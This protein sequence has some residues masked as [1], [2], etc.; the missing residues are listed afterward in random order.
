M[1]LRNS[2]SM[3]WTSFT[4]IP[5]TSAQVLF[6]YVLSSRNL[7]PSINATVSNRYSLPGLPRTV[8]LSFFSR[9]MKSRAR[10]TTFWATSVV[11]RMVVTHFMN[12]VVGFASGTSCLKVCIGELESSTCCS[13]SHDSNQNK[14]VI[15]VNVS[16]GDNASLDHGSLISPVQPA[17][18]DCLRYRSLILESETKEQW[19]LL[20]RPWHS[21]IA[22]VVSHSCLLS[23]IGVV[24]QETRTVGL[25]V[26][27]TQFG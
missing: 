9:W 5:D 27:H 22:A 12:P 26:L 24:R 19:H 17:Q 4:L 14:H 2:T 7:L 16:K 25:I 10:S 8:G 20:V 3:M 6:V 21:D 11:D 18:I 23:V 1:L 15:C 13:T